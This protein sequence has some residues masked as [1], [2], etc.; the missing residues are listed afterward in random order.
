[1][2]EPR[3]FAALGLSDALLDGVAALGF[4]AP[5]PIQQAAIPAIAAGREV[6]ASAATGSGKTAAYLLPLLQGRRRAWVVAPTRELAAQIADVATALAH[7]LRDRPRIVLC[8]GGGSIN[9]Q[10]RALRGGADLVIGTPGRLLDLVDHNALRPAAFGVLVLDEADRLLS[11]GFAEEL[12]RIVALLP[13]GQRILLSATFPPAVRG[14]V[15]ALLPDPVR[16]QIDPGAP[17]GE[18]VPGIVHRAIEVDTSQRAALLRRLLSTEAWTGALVFVASRHAADTLRRILVE[19][20]VP[21]AAL[22]GELSQGA[23]T[24][25]LAAFRAG[26]VRVLVATDLAGRGL[27]IDGLAAVVNYDL[28]RSPVDYLHRVGRT[29]RAGET[30]T[31]VSFVSAATDAHFRLIERR[32]GLAI[33]REQIPGFEPVHL[34][35]P[36]GHGSGGIKGSRKSK[37]DKLREAA[38]EE[39]PLWAW[40]GTPE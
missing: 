28:P 37:K 36:P 23:R 27:D 25:A 33:P 22:H 15:A 30:G 32:S 3:D 21:A 29:G 7:H 10:L 17:L 18:A 12:D 19:A 6:W 40:P 5:T 24:D 2:S 8:V 11:L 16:I 31:A 13:R 20:G 39:K 26:R 38:A 35:V 4:D 1:M 14:L 9:P 34:D